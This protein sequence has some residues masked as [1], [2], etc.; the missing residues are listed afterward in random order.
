MKKMLNVVMVLLMVTILASCAK[1]EEKTSTLDVQRSNT[2]STVAMV[3]GVNLKKRMVTLRSM[4]GRLFNVHVSEEAVNLPQVRVGDRVEI[5]YT[6]SIEVRMAEP[7]EVINEMDTIIGSAEPGSKPSAVGITEISVTATILE[8][9]K[10]NEI[11]TLEMSDGSVASVKV[12]N[13]E[14]LDKVKVGD[15]IVI[16][17]LEALDITVT[18]KK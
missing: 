15:K 4:E 6:E 7:G 11:A 13:P 14:N 10:A 18:G 16:K 5:T 8:L 2:M 17:Y 9:D 12:Q 3:E 1:K